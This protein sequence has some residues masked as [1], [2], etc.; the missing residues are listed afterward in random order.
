MPQIGRRG[1]V[2][3]RKKRGNA[4][5]ARAGSA[6]GYLAAMSGASDSPG[7]VSPHAAPEQQIVEHIAASDVLDVASGLAEV[8]VDHLIEHGR[9][10]PL[11][12][13][14]V[15]LG[16]I[17]YHVRDYFTRKLMTFYRQLAT[18]PEPQLIAFVQRLRDDGD[19]NRAGVMLLE[20]L[21]KATTA[22]K[23]HLLGQLYSYCIVTGVPWA[24]C[25][26]MSEM[27]T[28]AYVDDLRYFQRVR[29]DGI[30]ETGDEVEHLLALGYL[31]REKKKFGDRIMEQV[32]PTL[33][34]Y[35]EHLSA[36]F[37]N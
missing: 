21:D 22:E 10:L 24:D 32:R 20:V 1:R 2:L 3:E 15:S 27:I 26:R 19:L 14:L 18:T 37:A 11:V 13:T 31:V 17:G 29:R 33:S 25:E 7:E 9:E 34:T 4:D 8:P 23:A 16:R 5:S 6:T 28:M 12:G 30:G 35:G 36:A